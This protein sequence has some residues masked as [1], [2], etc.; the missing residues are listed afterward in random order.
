MKVYLKAALTWLKTR[1]KAT[2]AAGAVFGAVLD[3][4]LIGLVSALL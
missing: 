3:D 1:Q 2:L 4:P